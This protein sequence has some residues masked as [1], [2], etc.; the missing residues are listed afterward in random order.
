MIEVLVVL[1]VILAIGLLLL[2]RRLLRIL[3]DK[4]RLVAEQ[5]RHINQLQYSIHR[6]QSAAEIWRRMSEE[7][8]KEHAH[9]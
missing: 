2:N 4:E 8:G 7:R 6:S 9:G 1:L 5:D 3:S